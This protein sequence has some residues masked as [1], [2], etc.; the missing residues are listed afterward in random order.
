M[1]SPNRWPRRPSPV[2]TKF[3]VEFF[4]GVLLGFLL[5]IVIGVLLR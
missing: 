5:G 2:P 3:D 1:S 4:G